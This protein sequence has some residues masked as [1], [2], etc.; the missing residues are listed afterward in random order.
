MHIEVEIGLRVED[1]AANRDAYGTAKIAH[2][3]E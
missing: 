2:H 1:R 3:I